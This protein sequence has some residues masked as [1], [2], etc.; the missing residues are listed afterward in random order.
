MIRL[1]DEQWERIRDHSVST[2]VANHPEVRFQWDGIQRLGWFPIISEIHELT[3]RIPKRIDLRRVR[4]W[5][6]QV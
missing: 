2:H 3:R 1:R 6:C 4:N 5:R